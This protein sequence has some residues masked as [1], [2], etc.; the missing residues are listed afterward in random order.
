MR[1][2]IIVTAAVALLVSAPASAQ[3]APPASLEETVALLGVAD[4]VCPPG[5]VSGEAIAIGIDRLAKQKG[6]PPQKVIDRLSPMA[7]Q[8]MRQ[9]HNSGNMD[10]LCALAPTWYKLN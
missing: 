3:V 7:S 2:L 4:M 8:L 10:R 5:T 1:T 6:I 9:W